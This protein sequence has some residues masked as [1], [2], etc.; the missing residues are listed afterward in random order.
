MDKRTQELLDRLIAP[1]SFPN[2]SCSEGHELHEGVVAEIDRLTDLLKAHAPDIC[3]C[4]Y[5]WSDGTAFCQN[6]G[7]KV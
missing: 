5:D 6:C 7:K 4:P 3:L 2:M 1:G